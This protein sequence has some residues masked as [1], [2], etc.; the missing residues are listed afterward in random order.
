[1]PPS[2]APSKQT[3]SA[4]VYNLLIRAAA[5]AKFEVRGPRTESIKHNTK[6]NVK[7]LE[8]YNVEIGDNEGNARVYICEGSVVSFSGEAIV[9][10]AN[11]SML[12]GSGVDGAISAAGGDVLRR[13]REAEP[14]LPRPKGGE[15]K[16]CETG[17]AKITL[18]GYPHNKLQCDFV[19]HAVGPNY[20]ESRYKGRS[21]Q[22]ID[23]LL[24]SA[25]ANSMKLC[26]TYELKSVGFCLIS[27]GVFR[28][29][30]SLTA[31]IAQGLQAINLHIYADVEVFVIG[32]SDDEAECL[33]SVAQTVLA[34]N[35]R[36]TRIRHS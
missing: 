35:R 17:D 13:L 16:R 4:A 20:N 28:G 29:K 14:I 27:A 24:S 7:I 18:S 32:Y 34:R 15:R 9:N 26:E 22:D 21:Q 36:V 30:S 10:A 2:C 6:H 31:V 11:E 33:C 25:Y 12:G 8:E 23:T 19:I 1:M 5:I 3:H